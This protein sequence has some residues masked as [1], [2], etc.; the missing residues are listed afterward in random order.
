VAFA[1]M[2][3]FA[4]R[5][6]VAVDNARMHEEHTQTANALQA[7][8]L[9]AALPT[10]DGLELAARYHTASPR[11][12]VGGDFYDAFQLADGSVVCVIGD[13]CGKGAEAAAVTGMSRDLIRL[14]LRD[15]HSLVA[16]LQRLNRAL[17]ED[18]V[19]SRFCTVALTRLTQT[20]RKLNAQVCLAGHPEPVLLRADGS[21]D[22]V[23]THGDLLG[24]LPGDIELTEVTTTLGP[25][26]S[27]VL[28]TD[29]ITERRDGAKM[30]G[31]EGLRRALQGL[32]GG[33]AVTLAEGVQVA[34]QSFVEAEIRDDL[35]LLV[36][37]R[38]A[39]HPHPADAPM[40]SRR[41]GA[42]AH[43]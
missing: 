4:R 17:I 3:E 2:L 42:P 43:R 7:A 37:R 18:A 34:A 29:G 13:V 5:A 1:H 16:T 20:G 22:V 31:Q 19:S 40:V 11:L 14:L 15:G 36:A 6:A 10:V 12:L 21:T 24:V 8:L 32:A 39:V 35:A 23:G 26:D 27:L 38:T 41:P 30:F 9:P 28:Y 25:Q 33:N